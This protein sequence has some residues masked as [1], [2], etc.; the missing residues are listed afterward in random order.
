MV[1]HKNNALYGISCISAKND[2][3]FINFLKNLNKYL[4]ISFK[5]EFEAK[6]SL[7]TFKAARQTLIYQ[8]HSL[9]F[10][11]SFT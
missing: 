2:T 9:H 6:Y 8:I 11:N 7:L 4:N 10:G 5:F 3:F 1:T